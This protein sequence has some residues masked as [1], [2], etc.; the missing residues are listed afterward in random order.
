MQAAIA[1][2][3]GEG[4]AIRTNR[5]DERWLDPLAETVRFFAR[6]ETQAAIAE[7]IMNND[8]FRDSDQC[9]QLR[10]EYLAVL[11]EEIATLKPAEISR[12]VGWVM[13]NDP[14]VEN[15]TWQPIATRLQERWAAETDPDAKASARRSRWCKSCPSRFPDEYLAFLRRQLAEGPEKYRSTYANQLFNALLSSAL[16]GRNR[17]RSAGPR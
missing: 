5:L 11:T 9:R 4:Y 17:E 8:S 7:R 10:R 16:V 6:H 15:D 13:A 14:A 12:F 3:L 1:Q 2:A